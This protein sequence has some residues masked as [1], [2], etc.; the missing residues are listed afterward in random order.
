MLLM[1]TVIK[2]VRKSVFR[3][4]IDSEGGRHWVEKGSRATGTFAKFML[5]GYQENHSYFE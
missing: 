4:T 3:F 2:S 5:Y 1:M